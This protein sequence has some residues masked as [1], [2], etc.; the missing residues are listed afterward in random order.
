M[1]T[2]GVMSYTQLCYVIRVHVIS[3]T[4]PT[5]SYTCEAQ[6]FSDLL[7]HPGFGR[8]CSCKPKPTVF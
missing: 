2:V 3:Y 5:I 4:V 7:G 6:I 8:L 1:N